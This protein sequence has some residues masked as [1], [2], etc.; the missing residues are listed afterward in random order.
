MSVERGVAKVR[1][2]QKDTERHTRARGG[3]DTDRE[4]EQ[5]TEENVSCHSFFNITFFSNMLLYRR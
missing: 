2:K 4:K 5:Y 1:D 3:Q